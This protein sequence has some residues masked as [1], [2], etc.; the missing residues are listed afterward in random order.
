MTASTTLDAVSSFRRNR[1]SVGAPLALALVI[2]VWIVACIVAN[3][4]PHLDDIEQLAWVRSLEWGYYK[5][6]PLPTWLLWL[7]VQIVGWSSLAVYFAAAAT[8]WATLALFY[9]LMKRLRGGHYALIALLAATC[10]TYLN[11]GLSIYNHNSVLQ[12]VSTLCALA[13]WAAIVER[14]AAGWVAVGIAFGLGAL[15]K[16]QVAVTVAS[17]LV[18]FVQQGGLRDAR[19]R[20]GLLLA[21]LIALAMFSP[22]LAWLRSHDFA[23]I[24]YA[25]ET[26][27][28]IGLSPGAR[29]EVAAKWVADQVFNRALPAWLLLGYAAA[30]LRVSQTQHA[31]APTDAVRTAAA[32]SLIL[33]WGLVPLAFMPLTCLITGADLPLHWGATF[34][35]FVVPAAMELTPGID[36]RALPSRRLWTPFVLVQGVLLFGYLMTSAIGPA[37]LHR[38]RWRDVD[39]RAIAAAIDE[40]A[41]A[42]LGG[43]IRIV[44]GRTDVAGAIALGLPDRPWVLVDGRTDRSPWIPPGAVAESGAVEVGPSAE[45]SAGTPFGPAYPD[46]SWQIRPPHAAHQPARP[47]P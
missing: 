24:A 28:N 26:A 19:Q 11:W 35:I 39:F 47:S 4:T 29:V 15:T 27:L 42:A 44:S 8:G 3:R 37:Q 23:P 22:H 33:A 32:R 17:L 9:L 38:G 46:W 36:W 43:P 16:Y 18:F 10:T 31:L 41:R 1:A 14:R 5:H 13:A 7:P 20:C 45:L 2:G 6:P 40:P 30:R 12:W 34:L 21:G 25:T